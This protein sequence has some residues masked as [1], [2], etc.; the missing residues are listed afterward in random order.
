LLFLS[1]SQANSG[2]ARPL[3]ALRARTQCRAMSRIFA[4]QAFAVRRTPGG[5]HVPL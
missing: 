3:I 4:A 5:F 2:F 1:N